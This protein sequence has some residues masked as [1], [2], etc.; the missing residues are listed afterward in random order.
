MQLYQAKFYKKKK[1]NITPYGNYTI[2]GCVVKQENG[3][4]TFDGTITN[5]VH[6][7]VWE[8]IINKS[9]GFAYKNDNIHTIT[10]TE[11]KMDWFCVTV[12]DGRVGIV[13]A[14]DNDY[15]NEMF[16]GKTDPYELNTEQKYSVVY[17]RFDHEKVLA[18][19]SFINSSKEIDEK[20]EEL[21]IVE[22]NVN[23]LLK[24][25]TPEQKCFGVS[26]L[27]QKNFCFM[28]TQYTGTLHPNYIQNCGSEVLF[29]INNDENG[30]VLDIKSVANHRTHQTEYIINGSVSEEGI[31]IVDGTKYS[32]KIEFEGLFN[33][34]Y[35]YQWVPIDG[36]STV[37]NKSSG[38]KFDTLYRKGMMVVC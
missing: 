17:Y 30:L 6:Y 19:T 8:N 23:M 4:F 26:R 25:E 21:K 32:L 31:Y 35:T 2:F 22:E 28:Y 12:D 1:S 29:S 7:F 37:L 5:T 15:H 38:E 16:I 34:S 18:R 10:F 3:I 36:K 14:L 20:C 11:N 33:L 9:S 24:L 27:S 13:S